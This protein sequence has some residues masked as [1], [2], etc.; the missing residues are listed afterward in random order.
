MY[1]LDNA[2]PVGLTDLRFLH[3]TSGCGFGFVR[4]QHEMVARA[5]AIHETLAGE[6]LFP[7]TSQSETGSMIRNETARVTMHKL[8]C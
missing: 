6:R 3:A 1:R 5:K 8:Q 7:E 2:H 4:Q